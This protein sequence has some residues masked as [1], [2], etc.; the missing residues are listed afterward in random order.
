M[1]RNLSFDRYGSEN[2]Y[3]NQHTK[4]ITLN[5]SNIYS[6]NISNFRVEDE[7]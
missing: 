2:N 6:T 3:Y 4:Y 5:K 1:R 7:I